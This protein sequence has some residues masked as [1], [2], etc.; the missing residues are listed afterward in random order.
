MQTRLTEALV[1]RADQ[2]KKVETA[3]KKYREAQ[4]Q[5]EK[6]DEDNASIEVSQKYFEK[7]IRKN[8]KRRGDVVLDLNF[9]ENLPGNEAKILSYNLARMF[10]AVQEKI[11][12][13]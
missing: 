4:K 1:L 5:L 6:I 2:L 10:Q 3:E 13:N 12:T 8:R 9:F 11:Q 7:Q